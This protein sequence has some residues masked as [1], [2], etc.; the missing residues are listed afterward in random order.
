ME[1]RVLA[2]IEYETFADM[3]IDEIS[4]MV[5]NIIARHVHEHQSLSKS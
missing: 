2:P 3:E 5:K 1:A 4:L